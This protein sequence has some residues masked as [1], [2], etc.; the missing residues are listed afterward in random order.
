MFTKFNAYVMCEPTYQVNIVLVGE[1]IF[2]SKSGKAAGIDGAQVR[3][4]DTLECIGK[5]VQFIARYWL[6]TRCV[7]AWLG[8]SNSQELQC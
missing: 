3:A 1:V 7:W 2:K 6:C 5:L 4:S 8:F